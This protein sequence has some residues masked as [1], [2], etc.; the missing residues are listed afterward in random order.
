MDNL[1]F[2]ISKTVQEIIP[3][4][5]YELMNQLINT[6]ENELYIFHFGFGM[7]LRNN[8]LNE[9]SDIY[10]LFVK[11]SVIHKDDMSS[12]LIWELYKKVMGNRTIGAD[13]ADQIWK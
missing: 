6:D 2:E 7:W 9:G 3:K 5:G 4:M 1:Q 8:I 13:I 11:D 10:R 12:M